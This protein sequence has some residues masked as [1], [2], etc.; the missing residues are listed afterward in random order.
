[1]QTKTISYLFVIS[2]FLTSFASIRPA[3]ATSSCLELVD[4]WFRIWPK[5]DP[6]ETRD[7]VGTEDN[8]EYL[9]SRLNQSR[10]GVTHILRIVPKTASFATLK[11]LLISELQKDPSVQ[12]DWQSEEGKAYIYR[13]L[14]KNKLTNDLTAENNII[15]TVSEKRLKAVLELKEH[16]ELYK[17]YIQI[18][19][20]PESVGWIRDEIGTMRKPRDE[21][22]YSPFAIQIGQILLDMA[23]NL[24]ILYWFHSFD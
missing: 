13:V 7:S 18:T 9:I 12:V 8:F 16:P 20:D 22:K 14:K 4:P 10:L 3:V 11:D 21:K 1:M 6:T 5:N 17:K 15:S 19:I 24:N 2:F 23:K